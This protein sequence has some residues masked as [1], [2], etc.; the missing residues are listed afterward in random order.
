MATATMNPN[1]VVAIVLL[2]LYASSCV[3]YQTLCAFCI[4]CTLAGCCNIRSFG[5]LRYACIIPMTILQ[6]NTRHGAAQ[7]VLNRSKKIIIH[8]L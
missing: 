3:V 4:V 7:F 2:Y 1:V 5:C 6:S 8:K